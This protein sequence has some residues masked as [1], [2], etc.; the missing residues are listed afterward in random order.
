MEKRDICSSLHGHSPISAFFFF[1][2]AWTELSFGCSRVVHLPG[3]PSV[4]HGL[5]SSLSFLSH[6]LGKLQEMR[7]GPAGCWL[8]QEP[9]LQKTDEDPDPG[10]W[11][12][13]PSWEAAQQGRCT[14]SR[15]AKQLLLTQLEHPPESVNP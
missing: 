15:H 14:G 5:V 4:D 13:Q 2:L 1:F 12:P 6:R 10:T 11:L 3:V 7:Q 8:S 9:H